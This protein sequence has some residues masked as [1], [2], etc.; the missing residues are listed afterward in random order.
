MS[1]VYSEQREKKSSLALHKNVSSAQYKKMHEHYFRVWVIIVVYSPDRVQTLS[2]ISQEYDGRHCTHQS[3]KDW[4]DDGGS[5]VALALEAVANVGT[6]P[7]TGSV[8]AGPIL[9]HI[10]GTLADY[11]SGRLLCKYEGNHFILLYKWSIL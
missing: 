8:V 4:V 11:P 6:T 2:E 7:E 1:C 10:R 9:V 3:D 5:V